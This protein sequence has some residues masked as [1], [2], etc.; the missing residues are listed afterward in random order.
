[1][2]YAVGS[3][4][5]GP[6]ALV[7][8]VFEAETASEPGVIAAGPTLLPGEGNPDETEVSIMFYFLPRFEHLPEGQVLGALAALLEQHRVNWLSSPQ[9]QDDLSI[10]LG[11]EWLI[12]LDRVRENFP[13]CFPMDWFVGAARTTPSVEE[14]M[15]GTKLVRFR[16][17][18]MGAER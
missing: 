18:A 11:E 7:W 8:Q 9:T 14:G 6:A 15:R 16:V 13:G 2:I 1:M 5:E 3:F 12:D 10:N 4:T 17:A